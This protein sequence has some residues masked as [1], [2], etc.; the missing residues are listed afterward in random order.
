MKGHA[1]FIE[2]SNRMRQQWEQ[3]VALSLKAA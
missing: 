3:G 1:E 2:I